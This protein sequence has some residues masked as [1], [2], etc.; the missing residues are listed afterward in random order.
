[1]VKHKKR[2]FEQA[3]AGIKDMNEYGCLAS[4][5][6]PNPKLFTTSNILVTPAARPA[7]NH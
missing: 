3:L 6:S 2:S 4:E 5:S 1:M 7:L